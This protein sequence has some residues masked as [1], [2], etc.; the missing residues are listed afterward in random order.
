M[1]GKAETVHFTSCPSR[2]VAASV[3]TR[4]AGGLTEERVLHFQL[5]Q[6]SADAGKERRLK[7]G[8]GAG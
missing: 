4:L 7:S 6:D 1:V 8:N 2:Q 5:R 3:F